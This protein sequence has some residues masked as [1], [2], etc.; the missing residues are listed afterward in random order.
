LL[1]IF[2]SRIR[3][4]TLYIREP[5]T[6]LHLHDISKL[7]KCFNELISKGNSILVVEHNLEVI[8]CADYVIDLG[9]DSGDKGGEVIAK[10]TPEEIAKNQ[11]SFTGKFLKRVL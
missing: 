8:K 4:K 11:L 6:G 7:L 3:E 10:G 5:T 2:H 9:P 1:T